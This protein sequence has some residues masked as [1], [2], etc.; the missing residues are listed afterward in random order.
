MNLTEFAT[1]AEELLFNRT[2]P[3]DFPHRG[4]SFSLAEGAGTD[5]IM[6][7]MIGQGKTQISP[8][9]NAMLAAAI[10]NGGVLM[11]PYA[12]DRIETYD[13]ALVKKY[14]PESYGSLISG[15]E[16]EYL[17]NF[18]EEVVIHGTATKLT[19]YPYDIYG[20][21]GTAEYV[22]ENGEPS[23]HSWFIGFTDWD[24]RK[25]AVSVIVEGENRG[26]RT[27]TDV[28]AQILKAWK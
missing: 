21:T 15:T 18:M 25:I 22:M 3:A 1:L 8:L 6:Q 19:G 12:V 17:T 28:T 14:W 27:A 7:T 5:E 9:H 4:S 13:G 11:K 26:S 20:K 16:A 2:L 10:A 24:G 23:A